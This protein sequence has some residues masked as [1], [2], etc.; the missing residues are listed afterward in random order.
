M[1]NTMTES[2]EA[3]FG[4]TADEGDCVV[5]D[6]DR[7]ASPGDKDATDA[8]EEPDKVIRIGRMISRLLTEVKDAPLDDAS[9]RRL[10]E[11]YDS[12]I[13]EL[14]AGL[15]PEL[16]DELARISRPFNTSYAPS[17]PELRIASAQLV[18]WLE[19][20]FQGIQTALVAQQMATQ[21]QLRQIRQPLPSTSSEQYHDSKGGMYL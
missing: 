7:S 8:V 1:L 9:R 19:G 2:S 21:S 18:G 14:Q 15:S 10:G 4:T 11:I 12:S 6:E 20:L 3:T 5:T 17:D 16:A 13:M